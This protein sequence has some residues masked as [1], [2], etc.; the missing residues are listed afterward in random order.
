MDEIL[1]NQ[2]T[3]KI[4]IYEAFPGIQLSSFHIPPPQTLALQLSKL[5]KR[6]KN[7]NGS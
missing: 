6:K 1:T 7:L 5:V 3:A 2:S 4:E